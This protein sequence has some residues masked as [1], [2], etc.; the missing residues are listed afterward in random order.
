MIVLRSKWGLRSS[1]RF[2]SPS[3]WFMSWL[4]SKSSQDENSLGCRKCS[5]AQSSFTLFCNGVPVTRSL[6]LQWKPE[7]SLYSE[8]SLFF[9][10]WASSTI[11]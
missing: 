6:V 7:S 8:L 3:A 9:S 11:R 10:L 1:C 2:L 4:S 5:R